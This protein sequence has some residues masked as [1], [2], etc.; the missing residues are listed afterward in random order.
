MFMNQINEAAKLI[1]GVRTLGVLTGAGISAESGL[2]T[3]RDADGLWNNHPVEEVATPEGFF[4]DTPK[5]WRFYNELRAIAHNAQPNA[6]HNALAIAEKNGLKIRVITQNVDGLHQ[7]AGS[8]DVTEL[9]GTLWAARCTRCGG[10][11]ENL[12]VKYSDSPLCDGCGSLLRPDIV[13]F[14]E[15]L[16]QDAMLEAERAVMECDA[17]LTVGTSAQVYPAAGFAVMAVRRGIPVIEVNMEKTPLSTL[18]AVSLIGK[19]GEI[20]PKLLEDYVRHP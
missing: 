1:K 6:A 20:L 9:H 15:M 7:R 19:A 14:G 17:F 4:A 5:V 3:F 12:P 18:A 13:W 11:V 8:Q 10:R 16:P 2:A